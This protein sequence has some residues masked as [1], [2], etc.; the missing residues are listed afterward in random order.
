M[1]GERE[2]GEEETR[3]RKKIG[4]EKSWGTEELESEG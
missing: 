2:K 1:V 3:R 4:E